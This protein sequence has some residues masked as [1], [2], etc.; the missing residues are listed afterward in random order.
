[1]TVDKPLGWAPHRLLAVLGSAALLL[2]LPTL[3]AQIVHRN[4]GETFLPL[5]LFSL[6]TVVV[7]APFV[8]VARRPPLVGATLGALGALLWGAVVVN[9]G[10]VAASD[11]QGGLV[12]L[13]APIIGVPAALV[14]GFLAWIVAA[15]VDRARA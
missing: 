14:G 6:P 13:F 11:A 4:G 10:Q 2:L 7:A 1:M 8:A 12:F 3:V 5:A 9:F 15:L